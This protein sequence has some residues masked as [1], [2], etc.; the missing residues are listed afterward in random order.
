MN[1]GNVKHAGAGAAGT[2]AEVLRLL[3]V[4]PG[5]PEGS[6]MIFARR[7]SAAVC[8]AGV[9]VLEFYVSERIRIGGVLK[10]LGRLRREVA[11][12]RPHILHSHYGTITAILTAG[13]AGKRPMVVTYRGS[14]LNGSSAVGRLRSIG[15]RVLS[16]VA[17]LRA[18]AIVCVSEGL[19]HRLWWRRARVEVLP[20]GVDTTLFVRREQTQA[21]SELGLTQS[22]PL[23]A[24]NCGRNPWGKNLELAEAAIEI[25]RSTVPHLE[26]VVMRGDWPPA[27]VPLLFAAADCLLVTSR[28]EGSPN[29]VRE[30][31]ACGLPVVSVDVGDVAMRIGSVSGCRIC[32]TE[33]ADLGA[34]VADTVA[35]RVRISPHHVSEEFSESAVTRRL[36]AVY[37]RLV[38]GARFAAVQVTVC[39]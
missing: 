31:L 20:S 33:A 27:K 25:A 6:S 8:R 21:R 4:I 37:S 7:Q 26:M 5:L 3:C 15:G 22:A 9:E 10:E 32:A 39:E 14:D 35:A 19:R 12:F 36:L 18:N 29:V 28:S 34:A 16:Q 23:V 1:D 30:A 17:A 11:R 2:D 24:F 38:P 13:A